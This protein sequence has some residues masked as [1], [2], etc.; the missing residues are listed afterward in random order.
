MFSVKLLEPTM[1]VPPE[2]EEPED[3]ELPLEVD[4]DSPQEA[5]KTANALI[6]MNVNF[7]FFVIGLLLNLAPARGAIT[8]HPS[9]RDG[10]SRSTVVRH[11]SIICVPAL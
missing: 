10:Q 7:I 8:F 5:N 3:E 6:M 2:L 4:G 9:E 1:M 11:F